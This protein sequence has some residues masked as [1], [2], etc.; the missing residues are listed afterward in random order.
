MRKIIEKV[1]A[2]YE[3]KQINLSSKAARELLAAEIEAVLLSDKITVE[4]ATVDQYNRNGPHE[5]HIK[6]VDEIKR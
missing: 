2:R 5:E 4:V 3:D 1:L 6:S